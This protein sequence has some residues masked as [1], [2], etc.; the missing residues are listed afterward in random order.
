MRV[1]KKS[2]QGVKI[3][4]QSKVNELNELLK[5][6]QDDGLTVGIYNSNTVFDDSLLTERHYNIVQVNLSLRI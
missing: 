1:E 3:E 2:H 5:T 6:A 4:I